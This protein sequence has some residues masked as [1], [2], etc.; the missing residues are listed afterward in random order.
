M[1]ETS[2][3]LPFALRVSLRLLNFVPDKIVHGPI[4][5]PGIHAGTYR[6]RMIQTGVLQAHKTIARNRFS[7]S[8]FVYF[9]KPRCV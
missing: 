1:G 3:I 9:K 6:R 7:A 8:A 4:R 2:G 5:S